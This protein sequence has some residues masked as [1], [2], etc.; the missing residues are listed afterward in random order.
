[1]LIVSYVLAVPCLSL[2]LFDPSASVL[3]L[4]GIVAHSL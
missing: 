2:P 1:M 4:S 3:V